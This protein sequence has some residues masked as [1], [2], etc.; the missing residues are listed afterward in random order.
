MEFATHV[1]GDFNAQ[2]PD[3]GEFVKSDIWPK[4]GAEDWGGGGFESVNLVNFA[5]GKFATPHQGL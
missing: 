4:C 5:M 2:K 3:E 1:A